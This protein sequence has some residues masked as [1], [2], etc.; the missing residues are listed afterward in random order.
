[1]GIKKKRILVFFVGLF[2]VFAVLE[3]SLRIIG[4]N[5]QKA[6]ETS[7]RG[8]RSKGKDGFTILCLGNS[9]TLGIGAPAGQSYP[10][11]LQRIFNLNNPDMK[12]IVVNRGVGCENTTEL[13]GKL[14]GHIENIRPDLIILQTGQVN[15]VN[16]CR[17]TEYLNRIS[18]CRF[19]FGRAIYSLHDLL[20]KIR[21]YKLLSL[22]T[23]NLKDKHKSERPLAEYQR[24]DI[25]QMDAEL[26]IRSYDKDFFA[27]EKKVKEAI[28]LFKKGIEESPNYPNSY[29]FIGRI[30]LYQGNYDKALKWFI[31][32]VM[33]NPDFRKNVDAGEDNH[34]YRLI[35]EMREVA[36]SRH[37][38]RIV[39]KID[40]FTSEF[41]KKYPG[42][43]ENLL[44]LSRNNISAWVES[45]IEEAVR[46][47]R[48][49]GVKIILQDYGLCP[50]S[51]D[52]KF[53]NDAI[54]NVALHLQVP[55]VDNEKIFQEIMDKGG[56]PEDYFIAD[57][58]CNSN[59]YRLMA[60]N[61]YDKII[62]E[63]IIPSNKQ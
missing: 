40:E 13:L 63:K 5:Y 54:R 11:H 2:T 36:V 29:A 24:R 30:Y 33:A 41:S 17:Y 62:E 58:H 19:S 60:V 45:D 22:L 15:G 52:C 27:D 8:L 37:E 7:V 51:S 9:F 46:I 25:G 44:S 23:A 53:Y 49:R 56:K 14:K 55:L 61:V 43:A 6:R 59:G 31:K 28:S 48:D 35:R 47:C 3:T 34:N 10:D 20:C 38:A 1:M 16:F 57:G 4:Y 21:T 12:V 42:S 26:A 39:K 32:G 50:I 18:P